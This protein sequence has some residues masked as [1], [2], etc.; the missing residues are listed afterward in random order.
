LRRLAEA[1][2]DEEDA[3]IIWYDLGLALQY[4]EHFKDA[5]AAFDRAIALRDKGR[6]RQARAE[7]LRRESEYLDRVERGR[8]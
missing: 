2:G 4:D 6:Y 7:L 8:R 3:D 5:L 1:K